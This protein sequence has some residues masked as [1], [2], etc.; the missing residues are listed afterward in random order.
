MYAEKFLN[1]LDKI[2]QV[3][4][5]D[6]CK[7]QF[8]TME[9]EKPKSTLR[10]LNDAGLHFA[11]LFILRPEIVERNLFHELNERNRIALRFC[12]KILPEKMLAD[13]PGI[14]LAINNEAFHASL[15]WILRTGAPDDG[16]SEDFDRMLDASAAVLIKKC[17]EKLVLPI[18]AELIFNRNQKG[19][20]YHDL[21][22][23]FFS[24]RDVYALRLVAERL[25]SNNPKDTALACQ[26]LHLPQ[27]TPLETRE[28]RQKQYARYLSWLNENQRYLCF[29]G[30]SLMQTNCPSP[31]NVNLE[32]K[33]LCKQIPTRKKEL[34]SAFSEPEQAALK[35][36]KDICEEE[37]AV[38]ANYSHHLHARNPA[39]WNKWLRYPLEKQLEIAKL[40]RREFT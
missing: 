35:P 10:I 20:Y 32:A 14:P 38:L 6:D 3:R 19:S 12:D 31:C 37:K 8:R 1:Q 27:D 28:D 39:N 11:T 5:I 15:L 24:S 29:T 25:R 7:N 23:A 30:E 16:L 40:G 22:W 17:C 9:K 36:F 4:G 13:V 26:L 34:L 2:R 33:Y 18:V 21:V